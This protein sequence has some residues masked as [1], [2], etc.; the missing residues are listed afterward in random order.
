M[1]T[2]PCSHHAHES[3]HDAPPQA[4]SGCSS[5]DP[6]ARLN[7]CHQHVLSVLGELESAVAELTEGQPLTQRALAA[8][9]DTLVITQIAIPLH[10]A[11]EEQTL[12]PRLRE[13]A[14]FS[15]GGVTPMDCMEEDHVAHREMAAG[16]ARATLARDPLALQRAARNM[17][18]EYRDHISKED[19]ILFPMAR[20]LLRDPAVLA[21]MTAEMHA[22]RVD[23]KLVNC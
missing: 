18:A 22:R 10:S 5:K 20:E 4:P 8:V 12:F 3:S 7:A 15:Q 13:C 14:P 19:E 1:S 23:A 6:F 9:G 16:L 2:T 11:D 17:V 21:E